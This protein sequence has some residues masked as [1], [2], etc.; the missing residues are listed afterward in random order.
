MAVYVANFGRENYAWD[1]CL[2]RSTIATMND[3][4]VHPLW[5]AGDRE[6]Y[7]DYAFKHF[8]TSKNGKVPKTLASR[9]FNL[10]TIIN[11]SEGDIWIHRDKDDLWW[12]TSL[13]EPSTFETIREPIGNNDE[14]VICH[15]PCEKW[16]KVDLQKRPLKWREIHIK[17][18]DF[19]STESTLQQLSKNYADYALSLVKGEPLDEWH[20]QEIWKKKREK[21]DAEAGLVKNFTPWEIAVSRIADTAFHTTKAADG[22]IVRQKKKVKNMMFNNI[23]VLEEY[24]KELARDQDYHC[25]LTGLPLNREDNEGDSEMNISLDR[26]DSDGH[27]EEGNLQIVCK[28]ANRWKSNDDNDLFVRLIEKVR[29]AI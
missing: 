6:G 4:G 1:E 27:Y 17:A 9:W 5:E 25:A 28:F 21:A 19:L 2:R 22:S 14:V 8:R 12:T 3:L 11:E 10:M 7:V 23:S 18:R 15:K 24:I 20:S 26:I 29:E 13:P 16:S